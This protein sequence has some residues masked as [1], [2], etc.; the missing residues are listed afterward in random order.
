MIT[1]YFSPH[2]TSVDNEAGRASGHADAPLSRAGE[3]QARALGHHYASYA[4]DAVIASDLQRAATTAAL[5]FGE[6]GLPITLDRRLREC[7]YGA[8]T[9]CP[10]AQL[11]ELQHITVPY[12]GGESWWL[13]AQRVGD[14]LRDLF[15]KYD[16]RTLVI[17]GHKAT[18]YGIAYWAGDAPFGAVMRTTWEWREVPIW[19]YDLH[20]ATL[21]PDRC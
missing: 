16:G 20:A 12:P 14:C 21:A 2:A 19:R 11:D 18:K 4:L 3:Q 17:L 7:D 6:R 8:L 5:A 1:L 13:A 10:P 15:P 9:Q